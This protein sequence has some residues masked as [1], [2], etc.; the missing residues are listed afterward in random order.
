[1]NHLRAICTLMPRQNFPYSFEIQHVPDRE[2]FASGAEDFTFIYRYT[3]WPKAARKCVISHQAVSIWGITSAGRGWALRFSSREDCVRAL[4]YSVNHEVI[5]TLK[6]LGAFH[7]AEEI[8]D[9]QSCAFPSLR[10]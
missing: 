10:S 4:G 1:M 8:L 3:P 2:N 7:L 9:F 5:S 6:R